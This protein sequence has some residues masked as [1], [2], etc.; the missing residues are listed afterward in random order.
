MS[1]V[2][3]SIDHLASKTRS[4][5]FCLRVIGR[6]R[7]GRTVFAHML[8][9]TALTASATSHQGDRPGGAGPVD[10]AGG[11]LSRGRG[12]WMVRVRITRYPEPIPYLVPYHMTAAFRPLSS[13][14]RART[15][16]MYGYCITLHEHIESCQKRTDECS[17]A[18]NHIAASSSRP[19]VDPPR[20]FAGSSERRG[21]FG[22][23]QEAG[24]FCPT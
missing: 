19:E 22:G 1:A 11:S 13:E 8:V 23:R 14:R 4:V 2:V 16:I 9:G 17:T 5:A 6:R 18:I 20:Q 21:H 12:M 10:Q 15:R 24:A 3:S 7:A